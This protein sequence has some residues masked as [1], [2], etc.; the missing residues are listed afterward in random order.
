MDDIL[1][2]VINNILEGFLHQLRYI[3]TV[4]DKDNVS[5]L[6]GCEICWG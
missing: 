1:I 4:T 5:H 6:V 2:L 3:F